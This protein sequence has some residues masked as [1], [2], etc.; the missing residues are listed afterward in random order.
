MLEV[1]AWILKIDGFPR[2]GLIALPVFVRGTRG[3]LNL[4]VGY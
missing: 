4:I 3:A 2:H 1:F